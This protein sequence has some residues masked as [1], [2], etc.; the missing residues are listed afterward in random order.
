MVHELIHTA[1]I[2]AAKQFELTMAGPGGVWWLV[3]V[4]AITLTASAALYHVVE[5]PARIWMRRMV[6]RKK[7]A[8]SVRAVDSETRLSA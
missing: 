7:P 3:A 6:G 8:A 5:E 2:W 4:F 1:W